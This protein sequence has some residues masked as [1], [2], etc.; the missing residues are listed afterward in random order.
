MAGM[1]PNVFA[2]K[3]EQK[4]SKKTELPQGRKA[5][6][7]LTRWPAG[8]GGLLLPTPICHPAGPWGD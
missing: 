4:P 8:A 3:T 6:T 1:F 2:V 5:L 7:P